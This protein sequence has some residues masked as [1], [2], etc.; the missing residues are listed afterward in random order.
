MGA[1]AQKSWFEIHLGY[2]STVQK[3]SKI[4]VLFPNLLSTDRHAVTVCSTLCHLAP[5]WMVGTACSAISNTIF[6]LTYCRS[7]YEGLLKNKRHYR[8]LKIVGISSWTCDWHIWVAMSSFPFWVRNRSKWSPNVIIELKGSTRYSVL[9]CL[10]SGFPQD[11]F[12]K[13]KL[14]TELTFVYFIPRVVF[15][16]FD[17]SFLNEIN[18]LL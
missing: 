6:T 13:L 17:S 12:D 2:G 16:I 15:F 4:H 10:E 5:P 11:G 18:L 1:T 3:N 9:V 14:V 8:C 7:F